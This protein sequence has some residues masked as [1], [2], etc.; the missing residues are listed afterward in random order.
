MVEAFQ[1]NW[2]YNVLGTLASGFCAI[3]AVDKTM[4]LTS[5]PNFFMVFYV[6]DLDESSAIISSAIKT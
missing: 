4:P 5:N 3:K 1:P 2:P 6:F